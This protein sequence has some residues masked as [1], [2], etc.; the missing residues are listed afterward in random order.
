MTGVSTET[1][2]DWQTVLLLQVSLSVD[3]KFVPRAYIVAAHHS[4]IPLFP[5]EYEDIDV[6]GN[7]GLKISEM[8]ETDSERL[9]ESGIVEQCGRVV[10]G[11]VAC[12]L[13]VYLDQSTKTSSAFRVTSSPSEPTPLH[14]SPIASQAPLCAFQLVQ[15][16]PRLE[17]GSFRPRA[18]TFRSSASRRS[19]TTDTFFGRFSCF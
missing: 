11:S 12:G 8:L 17:G 9:L 10:G 2:L 5:V 19:L 7:E 3:R 18:A 14:S 6:F 4:G 15:P 16:E 13:C 1:Q